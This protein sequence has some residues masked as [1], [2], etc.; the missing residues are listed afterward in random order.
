[1]A[2]SLNYLRETP[3][4]TAG[5]YVHI[6]LIPNQA[7]FDI[8]EKPFGHVVAGPDAVGERIRIEGRILDGLG[9]P[10]RDVLIELWQADSE[11]RYDNPAF[12]G[13]GRSGTDFET[14][15]YAFETIKPGAS[16][17]RRGVGQAP[18]VSLWIVS[19]GINI[20]L[21][22][23]LYFADEDN[24]KDPVLRIIEPAIRRE[25]LMAHRELRD[26]AVVYVFDIRLQGERETV[27]F[28]A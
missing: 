15:L 1:M 5:P 18:H 3:S 21:Q 8:F 7:G 16:P 9:A 28:D 2:Q 6:G 10:C 24:A 27:F 25:T 14:G 4:Q 11:G 23:R 13:W 26:G 20:G 19:R 12:R 22:T 17:G